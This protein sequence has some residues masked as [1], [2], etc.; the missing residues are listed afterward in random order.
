MCLCVWTFVCMTNLLCNL[1]DPGRGAIG[2][3]RSSG[4][5]AYRRLH[6]LIGSNTCRETDRETPTVRDTKDSSCLTGLESLCIGNETSNL[7]HFISTCS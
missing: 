2:K 1:A 7:T 4:A 6:A 5:P 3:V